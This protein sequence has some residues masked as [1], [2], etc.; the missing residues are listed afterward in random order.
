M[1]FKANW[2][3]CSIYDSQF[4]VGRTIKEPQTNLGGVE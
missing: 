1:V 3:I 2:G 4:F